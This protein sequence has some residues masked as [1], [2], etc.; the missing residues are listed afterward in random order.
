MKSYQDL[1]V[2]QKSLELVK[3]VY[4][5][6]EKFPPK[7]MF[8]I[9]SQMRRAAVAIP[10]NIAEGFSRRNSGEKVQFLN[11]ASGSGAELEAQS[12]ISLELRFLTRKDFNELSFKLIEIM[13]MINSL[14]RKVKERG[15]SSN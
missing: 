3:I 5:V 7:E 15:N 13:K 14:S 4:Q 10:S 12:I 8:G 11:I 9:T 1:I 2:W 6:T